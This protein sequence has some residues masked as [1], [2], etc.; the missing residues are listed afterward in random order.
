[1][2]SIPSDE[3]AAAIGRDA[4]HEL[5]DAMK[6]IH[7][8]VD[9]LTGEQ[10][11]WREDES[12]NSIA[13]LLLHLAGNLRQWIISGLGGVEDTRNR[14]AEFAE[15]KPIGGDEL[16]RQLDEVVQE[17]REVL[18]N[19]T[20]A[21]FLRVRK[22]QGFDVRGSRAMLGTVSHFQGHTQEI[23]HITRHLLGERYQ[24]YWQPQTPEQG[25]AE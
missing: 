14:P 12:Q 11:W 25:A 9:Q 19:M 23:I 2:P 21:E 8:C 24:F 18:A 6:R 10:L 3:L 7:H 4:G 13:N 22:I 15:R 17:A 1:M 5:A 16:L 20:A